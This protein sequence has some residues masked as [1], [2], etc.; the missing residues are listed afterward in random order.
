M[1]IIR[2]FRRITGGW[3]DSILRAK[4]G[5]TENLRNLIV[6]SGQHGV[7]TTEDGVHMLRKGYGYTLT[8][9]QNVSTTTQKWMFTTPDSGTDKRIH[10]VFDVEGTGELRFDFYEGAD[11]D[12]TTELSAYNTN[13]N[14]AT[15]SSATIHRDT[16]GGSTDGTLIFSKRSGATGQASRTIAIGVD[17]GVNAWILKPGEKY[18]FNV[19][20]FGD[21]HVTLHL[22]WFEFV[23]KD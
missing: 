2:E 21:I 20:T 1:S 14:N 13:R 11:R 22:E 6:D 19:E 12:G 7:V 8:D 17:R 18:I 23:D 3:V 10:L 5:D 9:V 15:T 16:S 4:L